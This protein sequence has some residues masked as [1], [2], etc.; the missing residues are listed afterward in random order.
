MTEEIFGIFM[1]FIKSREELLINQ[2]IEPYY[3][4]A[5]QLHNNIFLICLAGSAFIL[6]WVAILLSQTDGIY[7][8]S[9]DFNLIS[10]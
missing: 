10:C 4:E 5:W 9:F 6:Y 7:A 2:D 1:N 3:T 8:G